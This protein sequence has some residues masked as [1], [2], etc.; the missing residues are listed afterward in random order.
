MAHPA[1][2]SDF[3][4]RR[5]GFDRRLQPEFHGASVTSDVGLLAYRNWMTRGLTALADLCGRWIDRFHGLRPPVGP[6]SCLI[7]DFFLEKRMHS[8]PFGRCKAFSNPYHANLSPS[9]SNSCWARSRRYQVNS[10]GWLSRWEFFSYAVTH[11][12]AFPKFRCFLRNS[13]QFRFHFQ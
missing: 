6:S 5:L 4:I 8:H 13:R 10:M 7:L 12:R 1:G 3:D 11:F 2:K 9:R